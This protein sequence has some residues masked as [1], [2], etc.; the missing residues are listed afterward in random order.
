MRVAVIQFDI[1]WKNSVANFS[2]LDSILP[3]GC[4]LVVL[5]EMFHCGFS[6]DIASDAM[7]QGGAAL[8]WMVEKA[9]A[10]NCAI[11]GT[12]A[13]REKDDKLFN[14][15]YFVHPDGKIDFYDKRHL[16]RM[17]G[18][19]EVFSPGSERVVVHYRGWRILLQ[20][21]YDL[22]FP[23]FSRN[24]NDYDLII[25]PANWPEARSLAWSA[26]LKARAIENQCYVVGANRVG[27][28]DG[29]KY[30]GDSV[31]VDFKG[32]VVA[33]ALYGKQAVIVHD[34]SLESQNLFRQKFPAWL[35]ADS[36]SI[37]YQ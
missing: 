32:V 9:A 33:D 2:Y 19:H 1:V 14:R 31:V 26:L 34:L 29:I 23:V 18:E 36:F 28:G 24:R 35:D 17:A 21:C 27:E 5:P 25:Y 8:Q 12:V 10:Y 13:V 20:V 3:S 7:S 15:L 6:M 11:T 30:S 22:R 16:F 4:D 37:S